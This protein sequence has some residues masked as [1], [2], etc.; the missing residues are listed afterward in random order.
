MLVTTSGRY[1]FWEGVSF[2]NFGT[3]GSL[4]L[5]SGFARARQK[6]WSFFNQL[7]YQC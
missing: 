5:C 4:I 1:T 2:F 7:S 6:L 3:S